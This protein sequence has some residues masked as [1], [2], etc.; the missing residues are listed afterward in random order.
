MPQSRPQKTC[1]HLAGSAATNAR[2]KECHA[3]VRKTFP[4]IAGELFHPASLLLAPLLGVASGLACAGVRLGFR[5]LQWCFTGHSGL[6]PDAA[7]ALPW[8]WRATLPALGGL[9]AWLV[10]RL[11]QRVGPAEPFT[12]Y[13]EAVRQ[14]HGSIPFAS[15]AWRTASSAFSIATGA[16]VGRE[17]SMIQ[18]ASALTAWL[19]R[20]LRTRQHF[21]TM[22]LSSMVACGAA[23]AVASAYQ[24]PIAGV[25]FASEIVLARAK[26]GNYAPLLL[27]SCAGWLA[28]RPLLGPGPLF[29]VPAAIPA[30]TTEWLW[31]LLMAPLFGALG[32]VY[33]WLIHSMQATRR[34]PLAL[35]WSGLLVGLLSIR[36][37]LVWG[38][39]DEALLSMVHLAGSLSAGNTAMVLLLRLLATC[40]CVGVGVIGGVLTPTLF[41]G[42]ALGLLFACGVHTHVPLLFVV[43]GLGC[44]LAAVTHAPLMTTFMTVEL[45]GKWPLLP[46]LLVCNLVS[47]RIAAH[48]SSR[49]LYGIAST[50]PS[51]PV[52]RGA[53]L[54]QNPSAS[55]QDP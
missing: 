2:R 41:A 44:L 16:A 9:L 36:L 4:L 22:P 49:S 26:P 30:P 47:W 7:A 51:Q 52:S 3:T 55:Q 25:F 35:L 15:T 27:A 10:L 33:Q 14:E 19:G 1:L 46:L 5:G 12:G 42:A 20:C 37:P 21:A 24:A 18:F 39:G 17:G 45:T 38:N 8:G 6:L 34:L 43:A 32:P 53:S 23:G 54:L 40:F 50:Q 11:Y 31:L 48:L 29:A 13:V 28:S